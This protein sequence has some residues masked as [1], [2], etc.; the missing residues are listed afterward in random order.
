VNMYD[1]FTRATCWFN[2]QCFI[3]YNI[4][5][6][7]KASKH[8]TS[9]SQEGTTYEGVVPS[10]HFTGSIS[11][12]K[13]SS[14]TTKKA[15]RRKN[16]QKSRGRVFSTKNTEIYLCDV[17]LRTKRLQRQRK[18]ENM[19]LNVV[20][21]NLVYQEPLK[22]QSSKCPPIK[23]MVVSAKKTEGVHE[24]HKRCGTQGIDTV[25]LIQPQLYTIPNFNN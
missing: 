16:G 19:A 14:Q 8:L 3:L 25:L 22:C 15:G 18:V 7:M 13:T 10:L 21:Y 17:T 6:S 4:L 2:V 11:S 9:E 12:V 5:C 23:M 1:L 24:R 20:V